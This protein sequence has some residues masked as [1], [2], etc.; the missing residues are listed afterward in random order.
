MWWGPGEAWPLAGVWPWPSVNQCSP[1][2]HHAV[3]SA[4]HPDPAPGQAPDQRIILWFW[5]TGFYWA[6][7]GDTIYQSQRILRQLVTSV[8][9]VST[10][11]CDVSCSKY[12]RDNGKE[13]FECPWYI[14]LIFL[15]TVGTLA[16][17][18]LLVSWSRLLTDWV[19]GEAQEKRQVGIIRLGKC[20]GPGWAVLACLL[21]ARLPSISRVQCRQPEQQPYLSVAPCKHHL[22]SRSLTHTAWSSEQISLGCFICFSTSG[23]VGECWSGKCCSFSQIQFKSSKSSR[24]VADSPAGD[25]FSQWNKILIGEFYTRYFHGNKT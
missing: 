5:C 6:V 25:K 1:D 20:P 13:I 17:I 9:R 7:A 24:V 2:W 18:S 11:F 4:Q 10:R 22:N 19:R 12:F 14:P 21:R 16:A 23:F 8:S 15:L 3:P